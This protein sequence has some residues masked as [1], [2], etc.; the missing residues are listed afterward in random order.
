MKKNIFI[1]FL[2]MVFAPFLGV[3]QNGVDPDSY[4][5]YYNANKFSRTEFGAT[6]RMMGIAGAQTA[7]GGDIS[8]VTKNPAGL[9]V[10]RSSDFSVSGGMMF[11]SSKSNFQVGDGDASIT[12]NNKDNFNIP[13]IGV[14]LAAKDD[15]EGADWRSAGLAITYNRTAN[16]NQRYSYE[17]LNQNNS[18]R[19]Y[20]IDQY[21]FNSVQDVSFTGDKADDLLSMAYGTY[22]LNKN[23]A[24]GVENDAVPFWTFSQGV[25]IIQ[26]EEIEISGSQSQWDIGYGANYQDRLYIGASLGIVSLRHNVIRSYKETTTL[27]TEVNDLQWNQFENSRGLGVNVKFGTIY[28]ASD[29]V[30]LGA[31]LET[32]T[33]LR[34]TE[35][36]SSD[37][38]VN[39]NNVSIIG[40]DETLVLPLVAEDETNQFISE[41]SVRTPLRINTGVSVFAGKKGFISADAEFVFH[42]RTRLSGDD[43]AFTADNKTIRNIY[44]TATNLRIGGEYRANDNFVVRGG[45]ALYGNTMDKD[46][47]GVDDTK[48]FLTGGFGLKLGGQRF[49]V[50]VVHAVFDNTTSPYQLSSGGE[51]VITNSNTNLGITM[52]YG[53]RF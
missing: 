50:A 17:G 42:N 7:L 26:E 24:T 45:Y 36:Y 6:A 9:G 14:V 41:Y 21:E 25:P 13:S 40:T 12:R 20:L 22:L 38:T 52:S 28:R 3:A 44:K 4:G 49:D 53:V 31:S 1:S 16:Y 43:F 46:I 2:G 23:D 32:P 51:P 35:E 27:N 33:Y 30:R 10:Y 8:S 5:Y 29:A 48:S 11:N 47:T 34:I 19:D 18:F 37:L 39:Y 15:S